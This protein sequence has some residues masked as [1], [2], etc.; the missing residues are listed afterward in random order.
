[1]IQRIQSVWIAIAIAGTLFLC[2]TAQD[3]VLMGGVYIFMTLAVLTLLAECAAFFSYR[4]RINQIRYAK[5]ALYGNA[6]LFGL[7]LYWLIKLSGGT[8]FPEKGIE[9]I[10]P[11]LSFM[12]LYIAI[13][14]IRKDEKLVKSV[15]RLR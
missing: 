15:D 9:P 8:D 4:N 7:A 5:I 3:I 2:Y 1:M 14:F 13:M 6:F 12:A 11:V 10:F